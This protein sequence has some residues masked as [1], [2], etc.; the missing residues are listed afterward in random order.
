MFS[1]CSL[2]FISPYFIV[3]P[4]PC[5]PGCLFSPISWLNC[6]FQNSVTLVSPY[7]LR[8]PEPVPPIYVLDD[9]V[10]AHLCPGRTVPR[11]G[12]R[13]LGLVWPVQSRGGLTCFLLRHMA[14]G[15]KG[16]V[17]LASWMAVLILSNY[18]FVGRVRIVIIH[19]THFLI[20]TVPFAHL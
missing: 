11:T 18:I 17:S 4:V 9:T 19:S 1:S 10:P 3:P 12:V 13:A 20:T 16:C 14:S 7:P 2:S 5:P 8:G 15:D 6:P